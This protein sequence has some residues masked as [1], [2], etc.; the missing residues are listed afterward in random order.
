MTIKIGIPGGLM[1]Y[2][3]LPM[4]KTFFEMLGATV[5]TSGKTTKTI[6]NNGTKHVVDE[7]CLPMKIAVGH[8]L[9]LQEVDYIFLPR[10]VSIAPTE[11][12]CPKFLGFPDMVQQSLELLPP[13]L[14]IN[15]NQYRTKTNLIQSFQQLGK[16]FGINR[17]KIETAYQKAL[18]NHKK[19]MHFIQE[20]FL[21]KDALQ[22]YTNPQMVKINLQ[23][24]NKPWI[25]V[26][27][28]PYHIYDEF[29]SMNL[30]ERLK[31]LG[32]HAAT[33]EQ[34]PEN[35]INQYAANLPQKLFWTFGRQAI[36]SAYYYLSHPK[37]VGLVYVTSFSCGP[38]SMIGEF[39][40]RQARKSDNIPF[41]NLTLDEHTGKAG[42]VT[43]LE[44][45][46]DMIDLHDKTLNAVGG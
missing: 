27:G 7:S 37:V 25:A 39:I 41:L 18:M 28:H 26:I 29:T 4:W 8:V 31:K 16:V 12:I 14:T 34:L 9:Q 46:V 5:V 2:Y 45:F 42:I 13:I 23:S 21:P 17:R 1:S 19:Y 11:Y 24:K 43:R 44:A 40:A 30:M 38:D 10:I 3:Y 20:G 33:P 22:L 32:F 15:I 36:G 35:I 6:L